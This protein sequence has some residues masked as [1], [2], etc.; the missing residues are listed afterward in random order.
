MSPRARFIVR[1]LLLAIPVIVAMSIFVFLM[2]HLVP[3]DPVQTMLGFR[4]TPENVATVREQLGLDRPLL[5]QYL[6]WAGGLLHGNFGQDFISHTPVSTLLATAPAGH[7]RADAALDDARG[8]GRRAARR[9]CGGEARR[10]PAGTG[11][12]RRR[13]D[14][15][16]RLLAR[17]H[18]RAAVRGDLAAA[19]AV[20]L[21]AVP[22]GPGR[23]TFATWSCPVLALAFGE[24]AYILRTTRG[25]MEEV[26][27]TQY[28]L[29]L[30]AKGIAERR[31]VYRHA[32]R[33]AAAPDRHGRRDPVRRAAR[34]RDRDR[35]ALRIARRRP[36]DRARRSSS[37]TTWWCKAACWS[38]RSCSSWSRSLTDVIVG[39]LDPRIEEGAA[40]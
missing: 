25:A 30:R 24:A 11:G 12:I 35:D 6:T 16:H 27:G 20:G 13:R 22:E 2:I 36:A 19:A 31:I 23:R 8:A 33:N 29:F 17:H 38:W 28:I 37:A 21:R 3:G 10:C 9:P 40:A 7:D 1:R 4:A 34:R 14:R 15:D 39:W 32:L 5:A 26:L 18:A